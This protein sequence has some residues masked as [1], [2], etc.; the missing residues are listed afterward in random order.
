MKQIKEIAKIL[1]QIDDADLMNAFL[2]DL[3]TPQE[4]EELC[5]RWKLITLLDDGVSQREIAKKL[6]V[7]IGTVSRGSRGYQYG[8]GGFKKIL[9]KIKN[10]D[11]ITE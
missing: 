1:T 2:E 10:S 6:K 3:L 11:I 5:K 4:M 8:N 7:S 9:N